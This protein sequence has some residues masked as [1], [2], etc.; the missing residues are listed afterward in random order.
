M[1]RLLRDR[2]ARGAAAAM[3]FTAFYH[4]A[5]RNLTQGQLKDCNGIK[6]HAAVDMPQVVDLG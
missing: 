3:I 5:I 6:S 2:L 1:F 4:L